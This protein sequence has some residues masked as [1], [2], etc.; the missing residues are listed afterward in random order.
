MVA[1]IGAT[2]ADRVWPGEDPVG[3]RLRWNNPDGPLAEV[4]GVVGEIRDTFLEAEPQPMLFLDHEQLPWPAMTLVVKT[5]G[6]PEQVSASVRQAIARADPS[7]A[8]PEIGFLEGN[9]S[10]AVA[11]PLL[12]TRLLTVF[13]TVALLIATIGVYGVVSYRVARRRRD[14]GIRMAMGASREDVVRMMLRQGLRLV[15][16]GVGL[17]ALGAFGLARFLRAV[18]YEV[19]P[20]DPATFAAVVLVFTT[21]AT[22]DCYLPAR[23]AAGVDPTVAV[24]TE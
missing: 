23:R 9:L 17:G 18:L 14:F 15:A 16:V 19:S 10:E 22:L 7:L 6:D 4:I 3:R 1:V 21:V 20:T 24:R 11:G 13:A 12:N 2:L 8:V 5:A